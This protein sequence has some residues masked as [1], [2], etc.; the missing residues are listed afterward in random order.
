MSFTTAF[1]LFAKIAQKRRSTLQF[2]VVFAL[3]FNL[4]E[5]EINI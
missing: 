2:K 4:K 3:N 5:N 1:L